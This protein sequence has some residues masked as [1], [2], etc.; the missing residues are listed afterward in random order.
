VLAARQ[1]R[2]DVALRR[3]RTPHADQSAPD[4]DDLADVSMLLVA[5]AGLDAEV[6]EPVFDRRQH[7]GVTVDDLVEQPVKL[8]VGA[9]R[10]AQMAAQE[11]VPCFLDRHDSAVVVNGGDP[12]A[13]ENDVQLVRM[14]RRV[15][16]R[17]PVQHEEQVAGIFLQLRTLVAMREVFDGKRVQAE[18]A[19][20]RFELVRR[21]RAAVDP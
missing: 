6:L 16:A 2:D 9:V 21:R 19:L 10:L 7:R 5:A 11:E 13:S 15:G 17:E 1:R 8:T 4:D 14:R 3:E 12:V 18:R 20:E